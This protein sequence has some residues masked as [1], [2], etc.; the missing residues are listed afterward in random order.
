[1]FAAYNLPV[2]KFNLDCSEVSHIMFLYNSQACSLI[3]ES[4]LSN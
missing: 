1:M 3:L 2:R 4:F